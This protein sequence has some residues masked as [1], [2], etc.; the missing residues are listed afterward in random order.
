MKLTD[1]DPHWIKPTDQG[2]N[3][4]IGREEAQGIMFLCPVCFEDAMDEERLT[5]LTDL[6]MKSGMTRE[7]A[8]HDA[9]Q[10]ILKSGR[11]LKHGV[12]QVICW[13]KDVPL[14][15]SPGPGRWIPT[16]GSFSDLTLTPSIHL[17]GHWHGFINNG[18]VS[19]AQS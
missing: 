2:F 18:Q 4:H 7:A 12:H 13:F 8:I 6:A 9:K 17:V 1:L 15:L 16:G 5:R 11:G 19:T 3:T 10:I 14:E